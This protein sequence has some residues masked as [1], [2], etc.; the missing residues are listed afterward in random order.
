M[1]IVTCRDFQDFFKK[2]KI[3][4]FYGDILEIVKMDLD[5]DG[6]EYDDEYTVKRFLNGV[7]IKNNP[8]IEPILKYLNLN[9]NI[10]KQKINT[11]SKVSLKYVLLAYVL[12]NN[13]ENIIFDHFEIGLSFS[14]QTKFIK[15]LHELVKDGKKV[16][17]ISRDLVFMS[18]LSFNVTIYKENELPY[19][20][21]IIDLAK[22]DEKLVEDEE[23][24]KFI[25]LANSH[26][27]NLEFTLDSKELLKDIYRSV[28]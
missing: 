18:Q 27:A 4:C 13:Y 2:D 1:E 8:R 9:T 15:I 20:A 21:N 24:V 10:L 12:I 6:I 11:L 7:H 17:V 26:G 28:V 19:E 25:K 3:N 5:I 22:N 14:E 23:I 16:L